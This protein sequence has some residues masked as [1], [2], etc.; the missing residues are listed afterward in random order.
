MFSGEDEDYELY[1]DVPVREEGH[2]Y[3][4]VDMY[5]CKTW[6]D[7]RQLQRSRRHSIE[8]EDAVAYRHARTSTT[9]GETELPGF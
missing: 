8:V 5:T 1:G 7:V 9:Y 4:V 3:V 2:G 6:M